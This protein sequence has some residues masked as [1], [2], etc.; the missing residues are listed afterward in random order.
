VQRQTSLMCNCTKKLLDQVDI[1]IAGFTDFE[2]DSIREECPIGD[3]DHDSAQGL[4]HGNDRMTV[5]PDS[6]LCSERLAQRF[7]QANPYVF[8][9]VMMIDLRIPFGTQLQVHKTMNSH[10]GEHV[11]HE[12][13]AGID[14]GRTFPIEP[15]EELYIRL[16]RFSLYSRSSRQG[17]HSIMCG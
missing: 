14:L 13:D 1:K 6:F 17:M 9:R 5:S 10:E 2:C 11:I 16:F 3:V 12:R 8:D 7:P 4:V 15:E